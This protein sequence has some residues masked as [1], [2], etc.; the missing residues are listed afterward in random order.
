MSFQ[1][2]TIFVQKNKLLANRDFYCRIY[3]MKRPPIVVVMGHVDHGKTSLLDYIKKTTVAAKEA[4]GITQ[5]I[6]AYEIAIEH[7]GEEKITFI[8]TPGHQA[9]SAM[10]AR[11]TKAADIALLVVAADDGVKEQTK[12]SIKVIKN[13]KITPIVVINKIDK[14]GADIDRVISELMQEEILLEGHGG[15]VSWKAVSAK[16]GESVNELLNLILLA[17]EF[18]ELSYAPDKPASGYV[19]ESKMDSRRGPVATLVIKDGILRTGDE[20]AA[21]SAQAKVK[22]MEDFRGK[23]IKQAEPSAPVLVLGFEKVPEIGI[24]FIKGKKSAE[25]ELESETKTQTSSQIKIESESEKITNLFLKSS[26]TGSL[27]ALETVIKNIPLPGNNIFKIVGK[28]LGDITDG[29][30]KFSSSFKAII[31]G[32]KIK[33]TKPAENL[34]RIQNV[35]ILQSNI[36][37][38]LVEELENLAK[39][40]GSEIIIGKLEILAIFDKKAGKMVI[41]GKVIEGKI[42]NNSKFTVIRND[43]E[44]GNGRIINLQKNKRDA[45]EVLEGDECGL[46]IESAA[47]VKKGDYVIIK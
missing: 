47:D 2:I 3:P 43:K 11:G 16:T 10:R 32:F 38:K 46:L 13:S 35:K 24:D 6:G 27:E 42:V 37:Y 28:G 14:P 44:I 36:I 1:K 39:R 4:G 30:V 25:D 9:F 31:I 23:Q 21:G 15:N 17:A 20:I 19:L 12:E 41:G 7:H 45:S 22:L 8:D 5:S 18:E 40:L 29:D 33:V 34:T 26:D